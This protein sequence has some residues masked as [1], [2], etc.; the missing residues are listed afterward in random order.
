MVVGVFHGFGLQELCAVD[1]IPEGVEAETEIFAG[2]HA[3]AALVGGAFV[4][5]VEG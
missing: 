4:V 2:V 3:V 1:E 5:G